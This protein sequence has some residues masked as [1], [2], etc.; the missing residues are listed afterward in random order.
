MTAMP[1][2]DDEHVH[3]LTGLYALDALDDVER[4]RVERHLSGCDE[5]SDE[6]RSFAETSARLGAGVSVTPP[7]GL[8]ERVLAE[9]VQT[10]QLPPETFRPRRRPRTAAATRWL[11]VAAAGLVLLSAALGGLAWTQAR[12]AEQARLVA[13]E[14]TEVLADPERQVVDAE[15]GGGQGTIVASGDR[16]VLVSDQV[17]SPGDD[18]V[19]QLWFI[20]EA[21]TIRSAGFLQERGE[22]Q[23][24]A[25]AD[26]Y[27]TGDAVAVSVEP[28]G[29]S[30]Q[31]TTEPLF[32]LAP[33]A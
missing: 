23:F 24:L 29:G 1:V 28:E 3:T 32:A 13:Q 17:S 22:G 15:F 4:V 30:D 31:P 21:G 20:D 8:R 18:S 6:L 26:G 25:D 5:C 16:V 14:L 11:A 12:D 2:P 19:Y 33:Q 7:P 10:R 27:A 9:V